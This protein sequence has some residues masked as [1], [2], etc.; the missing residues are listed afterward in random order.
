[1]YISV[2]RSRDRLNAP[3]IV[4]KFISEVCSKYA[5]WMFVSPDLIRR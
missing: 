5:G 3:V 1:M 2:N 4:V